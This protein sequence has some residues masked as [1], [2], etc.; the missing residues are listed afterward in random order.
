MKRRCLTLP[1][2]IVIAA[3]F[4]F[5]F[6]LLLLPF[7]RNNGRV[8]V[9]RVG[10]ETVARLSLA[11][12]SEQKIETDSGYNTVVV[13]EGV[14]LVTAADCRDGICISRGAISKVGESIVCLPHKLIVEIEAK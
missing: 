13:R 10:N 5:A 11:T 12:D 8:A 14:C 4:V 6:A 7:L 2:M 3:C 9:V 1:D